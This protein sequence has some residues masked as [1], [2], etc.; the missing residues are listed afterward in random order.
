MPGCRTCPISAC[1]PALVMTVGAGAAEATPA[2]RPAITN[3]AAASAPADCLILLKTPSFMQKRS[4]LVTSSPRQ[5]TSGEH[6]CQDLRLALLCDG[7]RLACGHG[8]LVDH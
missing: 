3:A 6:H 5:Y 7:D 8:Q 1:H 2:P 4:H